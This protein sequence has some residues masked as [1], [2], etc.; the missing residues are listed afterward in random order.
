M[1]LAVAVPTLGSVFGLKALIW[2][3]VSAATVGCVVADYRRRRR[4]E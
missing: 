3:L 2:L 1:V 4:R